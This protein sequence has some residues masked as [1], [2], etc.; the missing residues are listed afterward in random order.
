MARAKEDGMRTR[1]LPVTLMLGLL[2]GLTAGCSSDD[3][4]GAGGSG[5]GASIALEDVGPLLADVQCDAFKECFG[6]LYELFAA[7][8]DCE[9][10]AAAAFEDEVVVIQTAIAAGKA[11][12]DGTKAQACLDG[13]KAT[14]CTDLGVTEPESCKLVVVGT[15]E[16]GGACTSSPECAGDAFCAHDN[17]CP[18]T[19]KAKGGAGADCSADAHC[20]DGVMCNETA[21]KCEKPAGQGAACGGTTGVEC[22]LGLF[23]RG[24]DEEKGTAGTCASVDEVFS[25]KEGETCGFD[26]VLCETTLSCAVTAVSAAGAEFQCVA[27]VASGAACKFGLP[28]SCP[29][30]EYCD[31][32]NIMTGDVNGT[33]KPLAGQGEPCTKPVFGDPRCAPNLRCDAGTC[34]PLQPAAGGTCTDDV[35]CYSE[36]CVNGKCRSK[37]SCQ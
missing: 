16:E 2:A 23:C 6:P 28:E 19:C 33:C 22:S 30:G 3:D 17:V 15:V 29:T 7:G 32:P 5:G 36:N 25:A 18:G 8:E 21:G 1:L 9:A 35:V 14:S 10:R 13:F 26:T 11:S 12:Y 37:E 4:D 27:K 20:G 24:E 31:V 34:R